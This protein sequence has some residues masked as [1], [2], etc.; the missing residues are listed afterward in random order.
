MSK[1]GLYVRQSMS[2]AWPFPNLI[3]LDTKFPR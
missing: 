1:E 2:D 3:L